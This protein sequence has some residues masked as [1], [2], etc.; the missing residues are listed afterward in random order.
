VAAM[1]PPG[2]HDSTGVDR[3]GDAKST[4]QVSPM[5]GELRPPS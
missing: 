4:M 1:L 5:T 2:E 3:Q